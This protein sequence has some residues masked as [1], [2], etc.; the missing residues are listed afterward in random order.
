ML[1]GVKGSSFYY[2]LELLVNILCYPIRALDGGGRTGGVIALLIGVV[3]IP[4]G[5]WISATTSF[6]GLAASGVG[7]AYCAY[8]VSKL[9]GKE[10][11]LRKHYTAT[12]VP[13]RLDRAELES[14]IETRA[15]PFFV[16]TRCQIVMA[17]GDCGG[18]CLRCRSEADCLPVMDDGDRGIVIAS[19]Y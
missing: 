17:P 15:F 12:A 18:Q 14:V 2:A 3:L 1:G 19:L 10:A 6:I 4:G 8:G 11:Q 16:C 9:I 5:L 13:D 7:I